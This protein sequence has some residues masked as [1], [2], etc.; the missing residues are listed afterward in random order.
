[1]P[2]R[3]P[4]DREAGLNK[5]RETKRAAGE[6]ACTTREMTPPGQPP[7]LVLRSLTA[8]VVGSLVAFLSLLV[9]WADQREL[10]E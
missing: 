8:L 4:T 9:V 2:F 7:T 6:M 5:A 10:D 3:E 1:M